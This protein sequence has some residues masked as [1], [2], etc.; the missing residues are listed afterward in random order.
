MDL[1]SLDL[2]DNELD[3]V[4]SQPLPMPGETLFESVSESASGGAPAGA[5]LFS[6]EET[7]RLVKNLKGV[8]LVSIDSAVG[9]D[10]QRSSGDIPYEFV[11]PL[12]PRVRQRPPSVSSASRSWSRSS[13]ERSP[14]VSSAGPRRISCSCQSRSPAWSRSS[15]VPPVGPSPLVYSC[16]S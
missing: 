2:Q 7:L 10:T 12:P 3:E 15:F 1:D 14:P 9:G 4:A 16:F 11:A 13:D 6:P 8:L 5:A